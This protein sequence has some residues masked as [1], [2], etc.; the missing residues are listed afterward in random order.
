MYGDPI[1]VT[2]KPHGQKYV[3]VEVEGYCNDGNGEVQVTGMTK[4]Y[5]QHPQ[6]LPHVIDLEKFDGRCA[7]CLG[8]IVSLYKNC[9]DHHITVTFCHLNENLKEL[10]E[11]TR[12]NKIFDI[13]DSKKE[14]LIASLLIF[15]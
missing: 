14:A 13:Y 1:S 7:A 6:Q 15:T 9:K 8:P 4:D 10:A 2:V 3:V 5:F 12:L 11:I